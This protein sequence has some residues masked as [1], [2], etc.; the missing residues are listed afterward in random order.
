MGT[1]KAKLTASSQLNMCLVAIV[2]N[3]DALK[4]GQPLHTFLPDWTAKNHAG[5][6]DALMSRFRSGLA[7][8]R[9][10]TNFQRYEK[11]LTEEMPDFKGW[12]QYHPDLAL[13]NLA[14]SKLYPTVE[15]SY[16]VYIAALG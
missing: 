13:N 12:Q 10:L 9:Q 3:L 16:T 1:I 4:G 8:E 15:S 7:D 11:E 2:K 6:I 14:W 5:A